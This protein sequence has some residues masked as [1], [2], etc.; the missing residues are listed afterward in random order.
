MSLTLPA[1]SLAD[2]ARVARTVAC[3]H[4]DRVPGEPCT[5][6]GD[7]LSRYV[8]AARH[9]LLSSDDIGMVFLAAPAVLTPATLVRLE[10]EVVR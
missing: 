7:H 4:C 9:G 8:L 2:I 10:L 3:G 1:R 5:A 6:A